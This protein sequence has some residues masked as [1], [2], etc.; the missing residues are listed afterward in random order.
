MAYINSIASNPSSFFIK[1]ND[2]AIVSTCACFSNLH[3]LD[4][5]NFR[6]IDQLQFHDASQ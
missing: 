1:P 6:V 4:D 3:L 2:L 5:I